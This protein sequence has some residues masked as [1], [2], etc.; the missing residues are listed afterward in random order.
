MSTTAPEKH[1][2][3]GA[4]LKTCRSRIVLAVIVFIVLLA[5]IPPVLVTTLHKKNSMGPK[6]RVF[7]PLYIYPAP[8]AWTPLEDVY[9]LSL[10]STSD[11]VS[12]LS[13]PLLLLSIP[14]LTG[15]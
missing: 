5:V 8:G 11:P 12:H 4:C 13:S 14:I 15:R 2:S 9:V 7:V 1:V 3:K 10:P 6:S